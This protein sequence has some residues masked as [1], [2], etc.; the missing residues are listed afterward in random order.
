[1]AAYELATPYKFPVSLR[2][3]MINGSPFSISLSLSNTTYWFKNKCSPYYGPYPF[4]KNSAR[5]PFIN[6][7]LA[8]QYVPPVFLSFSV[9]LQ[10]AASHVFI[11]DHCLVKI[12]LFDTQKNDHCIVQEKIS[13]KSFLFPTVTLSVPVKTVVAYSF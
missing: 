11:H 10:N 13:P 4:Q 5:I 9:N 12:P 1:M 3:D 6:D 7:L 2:F 8:L